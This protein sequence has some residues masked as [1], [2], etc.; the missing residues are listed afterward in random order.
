MTNPTTNRVSS[1][2]LDQFKEIFRQFGG[3]IVDIRDDEAIV[4]E[5]S[6]LDQMLN[7]IDLLKQALPRLS[8]NSKCI[9]GRHVLTMTAIRGSLH[10]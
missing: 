9:E 2:E 7:L 5:F 3:E 10:A 1:H 4:A 6:D 8:C